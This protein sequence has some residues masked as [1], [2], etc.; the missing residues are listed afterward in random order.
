MKRPALVLV[1]GFLGA[2][3]TTL[4]LRAAELMA[5]EGV[6]C[7]LVT[8]D[9]S[10]GL[11]DTL[12]ARSAGIGASEVAGACFCCRFSDFV[13]AADGLAR[14]EPDVVFAEPV[15]SCTDIAATVLAPLKSEYSR[16]FRLAPYTVLVD[17]AFAREMSG[18]NADP[19]LH[20][21][22]T[23]QIEEADIVSY[24]KADLHQEFPPLADCAPR[25]LS[26]ATGQGVRAWLDEVLRGDAPAG[27]RRAAVDYA[28]YATAEAALGWLNWQVV[29]ST[30]QGLA[31]AQ[32]V[33][34]LVDAIDR[35][36]AAS[37]VRT[38]H[39]KVF[40]QSATGWVKAALTSNGRE[41]RAE[42]DLTAS[43]ASR[44]ELTVNL[45]ALGDPALLDEIVG[46]AVARLPG[47]V[48]VR[49]RRA[50]RPAAPQ[51]ERP[52]GVRPSS[53]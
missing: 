25:R 1:G 42:G 41:P 35:D 38:V 49:H 8:N 40:S 13:E 12:L 11:V 51:P 27:V 15:G 6:R 21:L 9:Q 10:E 50:F 18:P 20:Y 4:L 32:V 19:H 30:P 34:P 16:H 52:G 7:A 31:P 14:Y 22:F 23:T 47:P 24:S 28:R 36:L 44:H 5:R 17:P 39:L 37:A 29:V 45:R 2:G 48:E 3:K 53:A 46:R 26:A 43:P 33:G